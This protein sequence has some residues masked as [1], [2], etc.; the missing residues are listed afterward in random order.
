MS[1]NMRSSGRLM[2]RF[3]TLVSFAIGM[4]PASGQKKDM[5][6]ENV[7]EVP[8]I[9]EGLCVHNLFQSDMVLQRD[10][11][12]PIWGWANPGEKVSVSFAGQTKE[13]KA[14]KD[15]AWKITLP[16]M[17]A[18]AEAQ[19]L[20]VNG[21]DKTLTLENILVGD[22]WVLG[23]QSN[24]EE[25]LQHVENGKLEIVSANYPGIRIL[26]VPS[27]NG[28]K[29]K[30]G[31]ARLHEWSNWSGRHF[32]KGDWDVCSPEIVRELSAIGYVFARL[33]LIHI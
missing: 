28:P 21:K 7:V 1:M 33:S 24:M 19:T 17:E 20:T 14:D 18:N 4:A 9:G 10:K 23:G 30:K 6:R 27:Q 5:P 22:V 12:I 25:P 29:V 32:R 8:A 16:A 26:T 15:R 2:R 11:P 13:A 3:A 31:F